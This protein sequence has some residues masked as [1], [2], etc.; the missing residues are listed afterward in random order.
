MT[1]CRFGHMCTS[2]CQNDLDCPCQKDH[3]CA[4][5]ENCDGSCDDCFNKIVGINFERSLGSL[6]KL[7]I[8]G[9]K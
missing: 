6:K 2:R 3:C 1:E 7:S 8:Y 5:T 4:M 9:E